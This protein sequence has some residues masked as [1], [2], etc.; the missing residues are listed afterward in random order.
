MSGPDGNH[1]PVRPPASDRACKSS[2][3]DRCPHVMYLGYHDPPGAVGVARG[4]HLL[5]QNGGPHGQQLGVGVLLARAVASPNALLRHGL[6]TGAD[7]ACTARMRLLGMPSGTAVWTGVRVLAG[8]EPGSLARSLNV[9]LM[10]LHV[11]LSSVAPEEGSSWSAPG[12]PSAEA[13]HLARAH[14]GR[15]GGK[16]ST[17][18]SW[19][20]Y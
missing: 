16:V 12:A 15:K 3:I 17:G 13:G 1:C 4:E 5:K 2:R 7:L 10:N 14:V 20:H 11:Y 8:T 6:S 18:F 9:L 19:G